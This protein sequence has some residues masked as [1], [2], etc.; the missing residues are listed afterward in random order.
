MQPGSSSDAGC[1]AN[2]AP[3]VKDAACLLK[4]RLKP[5][6]LVLQCPLQLPRRSALCLQARP[7]GLRLLGPQLRGRQRRPQLRVVGSQ[8]PAVLLQCA[9]LPVQ[10]GVCC[11]L[12]PA[13][14]RQQNVAAE[15]QLGTQH[16][17]ICEFTEAALK[18]H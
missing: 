8:R 7:Q 15:W 3:R 6:R 1:M 12:L 16:K 14:R 5:S 4:L 9:V 17:G 2:S 13:A 11:R 10:L 18:W